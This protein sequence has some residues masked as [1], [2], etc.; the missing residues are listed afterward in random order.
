[1]CFLRTTQALAYP[2]IPQDVDPSGLIHLSSQQLTGSWPT[3]KAPRR[4]LP[5]VVESSRATSPGGPLRDFGPAATGAA[6]PIGS[7]A[8][9]ITL[10]PV[11][12]RGR[13]GGLR[14][15]RIAGAPAQ[16]RGHALWTLACAR[17]AILQRKGQHGSRRILSSRDV[18]TMCSVR[19]GVQINQA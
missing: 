18:R 16:F 19:S 5:R 15:G 10:A 14:I 11:L 13:F 1:M 6:A 17:I 4:S 9:A 8:S 7:Q 2:Q 3:S 12:H